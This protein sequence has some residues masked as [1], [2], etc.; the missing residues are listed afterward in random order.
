MSEN[1][2]ETGKRKIKDSPEKNA[3]EAHGD[4]V[5]ALLSPFPWLGLDGGGMGGVGRGNL[6][7]SAGASTHTQTPL[8]HSPRIVK[9]IPSYD[10]W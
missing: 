2:V 10:G 1:I 8:S 4:G 6:G 3:L 7:R 5:P 9:F